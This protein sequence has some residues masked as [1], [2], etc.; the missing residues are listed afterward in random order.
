MG[1]CV[2]ITMNGEGKGQG[3]PSKGGLLLLHGLQQRGLGLGGRAVDLVPED[4]VG[5]D[6]ALDQP[7][8]PVERSST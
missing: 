2:A 1:F 8:D 7:E 6:R 3:M 5:E 4:E